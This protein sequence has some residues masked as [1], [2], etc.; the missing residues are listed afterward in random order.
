MKKAAIDGERGALSSKLRAAVNQLCA[1]ADVHV[2]V[3]DYGIRPAGSLAKLPPGLAEVASEMHGFRFVWDFADKVD[4]SRTPGV[5][6]GR[7][8]VPPYLNYGPVQF[9]SDTTTHNFPKDTC[10][11]LADEHVEEGCT[12]AVHARGSD[13]QQSRF[14]FS[15]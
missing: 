8:H 3:R 4:R 12:Y 5:Y 1:R 13:P 6:G 7:I 10:F 2:H 15:S 14:V 11:L 9:R